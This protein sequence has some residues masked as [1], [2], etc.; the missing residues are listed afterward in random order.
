M[1]VCREC[2]E[3]DLSKFKHT[4]NSVYASICNSCT[5]KKYAGSN[6]Y[7]GEKSAIDMIRRQDQEIEQEKRELKKLQMQK[8]LVDLGLI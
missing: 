8:K 5:T 1:K 6:S 2:P 4:G 3:M 7:R